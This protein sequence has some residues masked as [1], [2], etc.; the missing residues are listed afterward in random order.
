MIAL[1]SLLLLTASPDSTVDARTV[2]QAQQVLLAYIAPHDETA[3]VSGWRLGWM[4]LNGDKIKDAVAYSD[5][6]DWCGAGGCTLLVLEA[7]PPE[8]Q[9]EGPFL[10]AAEIAMTGAPIYALESQS[11]GWRDLLV[12]NEKGQSVR[13]SFD[14]ETYPFSSAG[15]TATASPAGVLLISGLR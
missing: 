10:V 2:S 8:D 12:Q 7:L 13:L 3:S 5:D 14:G 9:E 11:Q 1:F 15:G 4:D 6:L